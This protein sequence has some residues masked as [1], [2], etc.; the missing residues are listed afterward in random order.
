MFAHVAGR[1]CGS[2]TVRGKHSRGAHL[3]KKNF[4]FCF[5]FE[6]ARPGVLYIFERRRGLPNVAGPGVT[7]HPTSLSTGLPVTDVLA[8]WTA[9]N[10][11][12]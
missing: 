4:E 11:T 12:A 1:M 3:K 7:Y 8:V 5:F 2:I 6:M 10:L 9:A